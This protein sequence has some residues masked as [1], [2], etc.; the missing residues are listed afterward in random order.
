MTFRKLCLTVIFSTVSIAAAH[1]VPFGPATAL[2]GSFD[3]PTVV[4]NGTTDNIT[5]GSG[6][7]QI[8]GG[9]GNFATGTFNGSAAGKIFFS[10]TPNNITSNPINN[11]FIFNDNA[12]GSYNFN[13][14]SIDTISFSNTPGVTTTIG[15]YLLGSFGDTHLN[16]D[17]TPT[18]LTLTFNQTGN[19]GNAAFSDSGS[20]AN[21]PTPPPAVPEPASMAILGA[22]LFGL[23]MLRRRSRK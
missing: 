6:T 10:E 7:Y 13:L 20:L 9:T 17:A 2:I 11:L 8:S 15:L 16:L 4:I 19:T 23:G 12:G 14:S 1:A 22:G 3:H 21:P 18:S 5:F